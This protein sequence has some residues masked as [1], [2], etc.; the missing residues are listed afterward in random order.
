MSFLRGNTRFDIVSKVAA[1][2]Q[3]KFYSSLSFSFQ[4]SSFKSKQLTMMPISFRFVYEIDCTVQQT[5][6]A[7]NTFVC[8]LGAIQIIRDTLGG[9]K[10]MS[11]NDTWGSGV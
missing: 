5:Y 4:Q 3:F 1:S 7:L 2:S 9:Y 6:L 11:P 10:K 8:L